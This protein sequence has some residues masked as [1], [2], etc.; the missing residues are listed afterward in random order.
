M[1]TYVQS[2]QPAIAISHMSPSPPASEK[3]WCTLS[4]QPPVITT[5]C[6][7]HQQEAQAVPPLAQQ[8]S[9]PPPHRYQVSP[10]P[11]P[12]QDII[13]TTTTH[14]YQL[15]PLPATTIITVW[16]LFTYTEQVFTTDRCCLLWN[17][18]PFFTHMHTVTTLPLSWSLFSWSNHL[19]PSHWVSSEPRQPSPQQLNKKSKC[20][21]TSY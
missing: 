6:R 21:V 11:P 12:P 19:L 8:L 5:N 4:Q 14:K 16:W 13:I 20:S 15:S 18:S 10:S 7:H 1:C 17:C 3:H 2:Q 9:P